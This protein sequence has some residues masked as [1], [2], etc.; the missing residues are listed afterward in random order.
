MVNKAGSRPRASR[1][2]SCRY[3]IERKT[4]IGLELA[5]R[6]RKVM[7]LAGLQSQKPG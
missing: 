5:A 3:L 1:F 6:A 2:D 7:A 4:K